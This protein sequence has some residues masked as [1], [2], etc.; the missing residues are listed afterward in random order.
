MGSRRV[1]GNDPF[2]RGAA[3]RA[4]VTPPDSRTSP[5][6]AL[7]SGAAPVVPADE[8]TGGV[9]TTRGS[10]AART[11]GKDTGGS[12]GPAATGTAGEPG[13]DRAPR[14]SRAPGQA[15]R[16]R[17]RPGAGGPGPSVSPPSAAEEPVPP[18]AERGA[19]PAPAVPETAAA[20]G[21]ARPTTTP[22]PPPVPLAASVVPDLVPVD[23]MEGATESTRGPLAEPEASGAPEAPSTAAR[24]TLTWAP[25]PDD[26]PR[27]P[28][29]RRVD[30]AGAPHGV[31]LAETL[32]EAPGILAEAWSAIE[33]A[34]R[35][36]RAGWGRR[37][38]SS[39]T[40]TDATPGSA[41]LS[42]RS[43]ISSTA[44]GSGWR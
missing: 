36:L 28:A 6:E 8:G 34:L 3:E 5:E 41:R 4:P 11:P 24:S 1:L 44:A 29:A 16:V 43:S 15:R 25:L 14:P 26:A 22:V 33:A 18:V 9:P 21:P 39:S 27:A 38:A 12:P 10:R 23:R 30:E 7:A 32:R 20:S 2:Q 35:A 17:A 31:T 19:A 37:G 40:S 13:R 42:P